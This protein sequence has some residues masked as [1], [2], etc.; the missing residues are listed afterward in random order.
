[1]GNLPFKDKLVL[2][3]CSCISFIFFISGF[4][5]FIASDSSVSDFAI[6]L[7]AAISIFCLGLNPKIFSLPLKFVLSQATSPILFKSSTLN[8]LFLS[9]LSLSVFGLIAKYVS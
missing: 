1:M 7:G 4:L 5:G 2:I 6:F 8:Y 3:L 9:G